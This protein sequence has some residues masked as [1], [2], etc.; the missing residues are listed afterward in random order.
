[1]RPAI[2]SVETLLIACLLGSAVPAGAAALKG[3][4]VP[5]SVQSEGSSLKLQGLGLRKKF[6]FSVYVGALYLTTASTDGAAASRAEE[7]KRI[8]LFFLRDV[9]AKSLKE[10]FE[11]GFFNN[12]QE[13][14]SS[15]GPRIDTLVGLFA[16]GV[17]KGQEAS[18]TYQPGR[19]TRVSVDGKELGVIP[20][21][22]FMEALWLVWLGDV[23]PSKDVKSGMLGLAK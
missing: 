3:V 23:P 15:L 7:P 19:G 20:G 8:S 9:G 21:K 6:G 22:D 10:A 13:R 18:F 2:L 17:R 16:S 4:E 14:L 11:E 12:A 5:D 1:M